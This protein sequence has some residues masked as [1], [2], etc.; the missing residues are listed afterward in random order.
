MICLLKIKFQVLMKSN[1]GK[2][3]GRDPFIHHKN[4]TIE[5]VLQDLNNGSKE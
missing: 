2:V 3:M 4:W 1:S 5:K